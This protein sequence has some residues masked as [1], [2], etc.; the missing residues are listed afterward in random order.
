MKVYGP[1]T[2]KDGRQHVI[3][4]EYGKIQKTVS[5]GKYLLEQHLG[6]KLLPDETCDHIDGDFTNNDLSNLQVLTRRENI[7]KYFK[8]HPA[9]IGHYVCPLCGTHFTKE[10]HEVRANR[11]QG[12][13]GP[14]CSKSCAGRYGTMV[15]N[16]RVPELVH[17]SDLKSVEL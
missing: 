5:Y 2:R 7:L 17:G 1:Y 11:K 15:Q 12:K 4:Y 6:R 16:G 10:V 9:E 3:L 14:F 8:E 13:V